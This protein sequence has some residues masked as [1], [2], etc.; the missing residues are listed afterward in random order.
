MVFFELGSPTWKRKGWVLNGL[1][2][3][4]LPRMDDCPI[5]GICDG[6]IG[7]FSGIWRFCSTSVREGKLDFEVVEKEKVGFCLDREVS[8]F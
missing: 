5:S 2:N 4:A 6:K 3:G 8:E 1:Y 7:R